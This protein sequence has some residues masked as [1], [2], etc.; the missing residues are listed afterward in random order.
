[1]A[2]LKAATRNRLPSSV[3]GIPKQRKYPMEDRTH[4]IKADEFATKEERAGKLS[5]AQLARIT[6]KAKR[7]LGQVPALI[8]HWSQGNVRWRPLRSSKP[9]SMF[10]SLS[11]LSDLSLISRLSISMKF[12]GYN[13]SF[14]AGQYIGFAPL[15]TLPTWALAQASRLLIPLCSTSWPLDPLWRPTFPDTLLRSRRPV[16]SSP[17]TSIRKGNTR[18]CA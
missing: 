9:S 14:P 12:S 1:M 15:N 5:P 11:P 3:F 4:Q 8:F 10:W 13:A 16:Q 7:L 6:A 2:K 17:L 18:I